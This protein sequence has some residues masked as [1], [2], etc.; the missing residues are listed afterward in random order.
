MGSPASEEGRESREDQA[1][2][3][4]SKGFWISKTEVTQSQWAAVMGSN[5]LDGIGPYGKPHPE[6]NKGPN[7]PIVGVRWND[8][9]VFM[10]KVNANLGSEDGRSR[11]RSQPS[12]PRS[13]VS[14]SRRS[15]TRAHPPRSRSSRPAR[16][17]GRAGR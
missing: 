6:K 2:V 8:A 10:E 16:R 15:P 7:L 4:L 17:A 3:T 5:P 14:T 11:F 12:T 1:K 9:Q 13:M